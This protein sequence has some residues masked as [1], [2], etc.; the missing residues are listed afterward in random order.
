MTRKNWIVDSYEDPRPAGV[1][2]G[3]LVLH[4][5]LMP[6]HTAVLGRAREKISWYPNPQHSL[7]MLP[8]VLLGGKHESQS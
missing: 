7:A 4:V 8:A 3:T 2:P 5:A 6:A 1:V